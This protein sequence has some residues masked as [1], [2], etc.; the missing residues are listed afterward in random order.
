MGYCCTQLGR[1]FDAK[2]HYTAILKFDFKNISA[3]SALGAIY[4]RENNYR[5][6]L[7]YYRQFAIVDSTNSF[8]FKRC[9]NAALKLGQTID[10]IHNLLKARL[11]NPTDME[12]IEQLSSLAIAAGQL[13]DAEKLLDEGLEIDGNNIRLLQTQARLWSK[14]KEYQLAAD[15]IEKTLYQGDTSDYYQMLLAISYCQLDSFDKAIYHL[16]DLVTRKK[17]TEQ[18]HEYLGFAYRKRG[19]L[20]LGQFH[21]EMAIKMGISEKID[22]YYANLGETLEKQGK[23]REAIAQYEKAYSYNS[24]AAYLFCL[25]YNYDLAY[26]EKR[27]ALKYYKQYLASQDKEYQDY[28]L[29]R[30]EA[31]KNITK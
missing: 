21:Y 19:D 12:V 4:E 11:L 29:K 31:L 8:A 16:E 5:E 3:L 27:T 1:Y 30:V 23:Y 17:D 7:L 20:A 25:G 18:T 6:A 2:S 14:R 15:A 10:A 9:G 26:K 13:E 24:K 28:T 22:A